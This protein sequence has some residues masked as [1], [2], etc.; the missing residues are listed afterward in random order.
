MAKFSVVLL[1]ATVVCSRGAPPR[2]S[3]NQV[4][5]EYGESLPVEPEA[6]VVLA[7][8]TSDFG[9]N[10]VAPTRAG[11]IGVSSPA[12]PEV[13]RKGRKQSKTYFAN[14]PIGVQ[15]LPSAIPSSYG[16]NE[17]YGY[18]QQ[19]QE[20]AASRKK[21]QDSDIFFIRLPPTPYAYVPGI[22]YISQPPTFTSNPFKTSRP[23][24]RPEV[25]YPAQKPQVP[26]IR[27]PVD[28]VSNGKPTSVYHW[29][30][31]KNHAD[32]RDSSVIKL[33]K[34]PYVFNGKPNR[35]HLMKPD[36]SQTMQHRSSSFVNDYDYAFPVRTI[37]D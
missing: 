15:Y 23:S 24:K 1:L 29:R 11:S 20:R 18:G 30:P 7:E 5:L 4:S 37:F 16:Q 28:F 36:S 35:V 2:T 33:N 27:P 17:Y 19:N 32:K 12:K 14:Y 9:E 31:T 22:G 13:T 10:D 25:S 26:F 34:G 8:D 21:Y 3:D 6:D